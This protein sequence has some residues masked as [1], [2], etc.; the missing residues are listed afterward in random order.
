MVMMT[1]K[2]FQTPWIDCRVSRF[3][4]RSGKEESVRF[5]TSFYASLMHISAD[6][7]E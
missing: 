2:T 3:S 5:M 7:Q 1:P 6:A 4:T